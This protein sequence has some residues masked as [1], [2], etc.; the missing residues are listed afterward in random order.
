MQPV[1]EDALSL[2]KQFEESGKINK[3]ETMYK[4][5]LL[6]AIKERGANS[7]LEAYAMHRL[8]CFYENQG[9]ESEANSLW[10]QIVATM[11]QLSRQ[12]RLPVKPAEQDLC[13]DISSAI[14][15]S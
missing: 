9:R 6:Q 1:S 2:A 5:A 7:P 11:Q 10:E 4:R 14:V 3:A 15:L 12:G 8:M 13:S